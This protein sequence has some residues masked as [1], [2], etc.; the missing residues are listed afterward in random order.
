MTLCFCIFARPYRSKLPSEAKTTPECCCEHHPANWAPLFGVHFWS[1]LSA[2]CAFFSV[3]VFFHNF[4]GFPFLHDPI[5]YDANR[6]ANNNGHF[7]K[8]LMLTLAIWS[9]LMLTHTFR[10]SFE[11]NARYQ[12]GLVFFRF[13]FLLFFCSFLKRF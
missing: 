13:F 11:Q 5:E 10:S 4:G 8:K 12:C 6:A 3:S 1:I 9:R 7:S 2:D